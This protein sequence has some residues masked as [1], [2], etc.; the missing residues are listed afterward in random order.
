MTDQA[1]LIALVDVHYEGQ[2]A[3]AACVTA[4]NWD[5]ATARDEW[6]VEVPHVAEYR[7]GFFFER[8]L[9]S[10]LAVLERAPTELRVI[11]VDGYVVLDEQGRPGLGAHLFEHLGKRI[12]VV[13]IAKRSFARSEFATRVVRGS[14]QSPLFVTALGIS[15][16]EAALRVQQMHGPHRIP[17]LCTRVDHL[18]RGLA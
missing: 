8:E 4:L 14:S 7:P 6:T 13:G 17:T 15:D 2:G 10:I 11:V 9:P 1:G 12:P 16:A 5:D 18:C 3:R